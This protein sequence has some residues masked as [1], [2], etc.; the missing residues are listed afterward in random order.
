MQH[1]DSE[2]CTDKTQTY[3]LHACIYNSHGV[4][5]PPPSFFPF[6]HFALALTLCSCQKC[7]TMMPELCQNY[8]RL[9]PESCQESARLKPELCQKHG[10]IYTRSLPEICQNYLIR[11]SNAESNVFQLCVKTYR[12]FTQPSIYMRIKTFS[13]RIN[14][15]ARS[16]KTYRIY[17]RYTGIPYA[18]PHSGTIKMCVVIVAV[19]SIGP[20]H[21]ELRSCSSATRKSESD[22]H[23]CLFHP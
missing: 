12:K 2:G 5:T 20:L 19:V 22:K 10:R 3:S 13:L 18:T 15:R 16:V 4:R 6:W 23:S 21:G 7:E 8:A 9:I 17:L 11:K 1:V 14:A